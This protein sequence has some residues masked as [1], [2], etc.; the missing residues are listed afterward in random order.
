[1]QLAAHRA[2]E[3]RHPP[4]NRHVDVLVVLLVREALR[5]QLFLYLREAREQLITVAVG[6]DLPCGEHAGVRTRL[7]DVLRPEATIEG[8]RGI[9]SLEVLMLWLVEARHAAAVYWRGRRYDPLSRRLLP[10]RGAR[11]TRQRDSKAE[12]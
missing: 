3:L 1:M 9:K 6:D 4:L 10:A 7:R 8:D 12:P 2:G 5:A 11:E